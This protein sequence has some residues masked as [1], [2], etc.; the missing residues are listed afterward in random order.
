MRKCAQCC[1]PVPGDMGPALCPSCL[2][3]E[4]QARAAK[5]IVDSISSRPSVGAFNSSPSSGTW[6][7]ADTLV[8]RI[9]MA[10]IIAVVGGGLSKYLTSSLNQDIAIWVNVISALGGGCIG[11]M[12]GMLFWKTIKIIAIIAV[13]LLLIGVAFLVCNAVFSGVV[14][15]LHH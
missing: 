8:S 2:R 12:F 11:Y 4:A 15:G 13:V 9:I 6:T 1:E 3:I 10:I 5:K 7:E 14:E